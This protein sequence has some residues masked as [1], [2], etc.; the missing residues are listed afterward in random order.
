MTKPEAEEQV[1]ILKDV[2][3]YCPLIKDKC[4]NRCICFLPAH[5]II[6]V[7]NG[8]TYDAIGNCCNNAMIWGKK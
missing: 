7:E 4:K 8:G 3:P 5:I 6:E 1:E 2:L